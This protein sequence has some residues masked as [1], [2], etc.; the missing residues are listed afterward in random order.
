MNFS[1]TLSPL[2]L[3]SSSLPLFDV[4]LLDGFKIFAYFSLS[5]PLYISASAVVSISSY[6]YANPLNML[7]NLRRDT[8]RLFACC[9]FCGRAKRSCKIFKSAFFTSSR[10]DCLER[11][12]LVNLIFIEKFMEASEGLVGRVWLDVNDRLESTL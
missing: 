9:G 10:I 5:S 7:L 11:I 6:L 8:F 2:R 12:S 3:L 1:L 4:L